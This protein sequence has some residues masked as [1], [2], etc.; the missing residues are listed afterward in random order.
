MNRKNLILLAAILVILAVL[1]VLKQAK[2]QPIPI[3]EAVDLPEVVPGDLAKADLGKLELYAG[4]KPDEKVVLARV[5]DDPEAWSVSSHYDAPVDKEKIGEFLDTLIGMKGEVREKAASEEALE[6]YELSDDRAFRVVG[7][8]KD[9]EEPA[10][11]VLVGKKADYKQVFVRAGDS[12]DVLLLN[13]NL[14]SDVGVWQDDMEEAPEAND[15]LDK[16]VVD[17]DKDTID[18]VAL[19]APHKRLV[20]E[21]REKEVEKPE[22]EASQE[23]EEAPE[24]A[25]PEPPAAPEYEWV[26]AEGGLGATHKQPGLETLLRAFDPLNAT[27]VVDPAKKAEWGLDPPAFTCTVSSTELDE[28]IVL[29]AGRPDPSSDD[30]YVRVASREQDI[31]Y[32]VSKYNFERAFAVGKGGELFDLPGLS[33]VSGDVQRIEVTQP[34][35]AVVLVKEDGQWTVAEPAVDLETQSNTLSSMAGALAVWKPGDYADSADGTGLDAS[36]RKV[37]FTVSKGEGQEP[38]VHT[39]VL[40]DDSSEMEGAFARLDD[41]ETPLVMRRSDMNKIFISPKELYELRLFDLVEE[42]ITSVELQREADSFTLARGEDTWTLT[43]GGETVEADDEAVD[44]LLSA[45]VDLQAEDLLFGQTELGQEPAATLVLTQED[46]TQATL[47]LG[48]EK[49][50]SRPVVLAGKAAVF[51][52]DSLD[53]AELLPSIESLKPEEPA[54]E[55]EEAVAEGED[56]EETAPEAVTIE[57]PAGAEEEPAENPVPEQETPAEE[58][59]SEEDAEAGGE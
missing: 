15:W 40:G 24:E 7:Y 58:A 6:Q 4:P 34:A 5:P 25:T 43:A 59:Q 13:K 3:E 39:I 36:N 8:K 53:A 19:T 11:T 37:S 23:G 28:D 26:V 44:P 27:D 57:L 22:E 31:V 20:F 12:N 38:E 49:D 29:E 10:F 1:V 16:L 54:P 52:L 47:A 35:G 41:G 55:P 2:E 32:K 30:G 45:I 56:L 33:L 51:T 9:A 14:R 48:A 17:V 18:R 50:G 42:D 21:K 46:G